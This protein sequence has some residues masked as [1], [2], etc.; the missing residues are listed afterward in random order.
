[1][2]IFIKYIV[3]F[4][5][6]FN[7]INAKAA[8]VITDLEEELNP[9]YISAE[10]KGAM[11]IPHP[12]M[13]KMLLENN[14][15]NTSTGRILMIGYYFNVKYPEDAI[16]YDFSDDVAA[17][18]T[19]LSPTEIIDKT[20][21]IRL[22]VKAFRWGKIKFKDISAEIIAPKAPPL[23]VDDDEY[24]LAGSIDYIP[25]PDG[26][27]A[28]I[29][30]FKKV[31]SY[32]TNP[33]DVE[34]MEAYRLRQLEKKQSTNKTNF[35]KFQSMVSKL[36][37]SKIPRYGIDL[38]N[39]FIGNAGTSHWV[40]NNGFKARLIS[41]LAQISDASKII[42]GMHIITPNHRFMLANNLSEELQK[43]QIELISSQ[44]V[45]SYKV[46]YPLSLPVA[47]EEMIH[48]YSGD[49]SFPIIIETQNPNEE[50]KFSAKITY[51]SCDG[52]I[53]CEKQEIVSELYIEKSTD[54][55]SS[56]IKNFAKQSYYNI[57]KDKHDYV[58]IKDIYA[59][60]ENDN[61]EQIN[62]VVEFDKAPKNF[63]LLIEDD[64]NTKF[65]TPKISI[66]GKYIYAFVTPLTNTDKLLNSDLTV[67]VRLNPYSSIRNVIKLVDS[68]RK[69]LNKTNLLNMLLMS[70]C[71]GLLFN[72][73]PMGFAF[74]SFNIA[75]IG[76]KSEKQN[77]DYIFMIIFSIFI[78][79]LFIGAAFSYFEINMVWGAQYTNLFYLSFYIFVS[80]AMCFSVKYK[81]HLL[82]SNHNL[83]ALL[84]GIL[85][86]PSIAFS[87][88]PY[89]EKLCNN[90]VLSDY[91]TLLSVII[92]LSVGLSIPYL[93]ML[94]FHR[95]VLNKKI[96]YLF[97]N[98]GSAAA[99]I[100]FIYL[101]G[102]LF[103][104]IPLQFYVKSI[105]LIALIALLYKYFY[106]F[107]DALYLTDLSSCKKKI[108]EHIILIIALTATIFIASKIDNGIELK[109]RQSPIL[110]SDQQ[111][112]SMTSEGK[113]V[114][115]GITS[116]WSF[117][118]NI[119]KAVTLNHIALKR[120][121][122]AYNAQYIEI[123]A[124][125]ITP[126]IKEI[127]AQHDRDKLPLYILYN[128]NMNKGFVLPRLLNV[129]DVEQVIQSFMI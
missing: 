124:T 28:V 35:E 12:I 87:Y 102:I 21:Y 111:I 22:L 10:F 88:T 9:K 129:T 30:E 107:V 26:S 109:N 84:Y 43:P 49:L 79:L 65:S 37:F 50:V 70:L 75:Q 91:K 64:K 11:N 59:V 55:T 31:V 67:S 60:V 6:S 128:V 94:I 68:E 125:N 52:R 44:N 47:H 23:V 3:F 8:N 40:E 96:R 80:L 83:K 53:N 90:I 117:V 32:S 25:V 97:I 92:A 110:L 98:L 2:I 14:K 61:V 112:N 99:L 27:F 38:P 77:V 93:L 85:I 63:S 113:T 114:I 86:V 115:L 20:N 41:E 95:F 72:F 48:A 45:K 122:R 58:K 7:I 29:N 51:Q 16:E 120:F 54:N 106:N 34:A 39:P 24:A 74:L 116:D 73:T 81:E 57:P 103:M 46:Y 104:I 71:V 15:N 19:D 76:Y 4:I 1:M 69:N 118:S 42:A 5:L 89:L 56:A 36:E 108:T 62:V 13:F 100:V 101:I 78:T 127:L 119:N 66:N 123:N 17:I 105:L 33:K 82:A 126:A 121:E 18:F